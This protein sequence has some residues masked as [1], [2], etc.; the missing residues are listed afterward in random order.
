MASFR[1]EMVLRRDEVTLGIVT[2]TGVLAFQLSD[3]KGS[4]TERFLCVCVLGSVDV[5]SDSLSEYGD[6]KRILVR[7]PP[8]YKSQN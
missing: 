1:A 2:V 5:V 8:C 3:I 4:I 6:K 7:V